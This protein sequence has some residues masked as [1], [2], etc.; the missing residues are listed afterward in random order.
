MKII[1][2][3]FPLLVSLTRR[4]EK[5]R[6]F[7]NTIALKLFAVK[8]YNHLIKSMSKKSAVVMTKE[9]KAETWYNALVI[10]VDYN[11]ITFFVHKKIVFFIDQSTKDS[12]LL[13][14]F[15]VM[16]FFKYCPGN[17]K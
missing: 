17:V 13:Y 10:T 1:R 6:A 15:R 8:I 3:F 9:C 7:L 5:Y 11:S 4:I 2:T 14:T 16:I 12:I